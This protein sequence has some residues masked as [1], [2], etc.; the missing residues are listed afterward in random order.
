MKDYYRI[1]EV[2]SEASAEVVTRA[3]RTLAQKYHPDRYHS[4]DKSRMNAH[5]QMLNEAYETLGDETRR[6]RYDRQWQRFEAERPLR[7]RAQKRVMTVQ[8]L[9][10]GFCV[11]VLV[12][13]LVRGG[14]QAFMMSPVVKVVMLGGLLWVLYGLSVRRDARQ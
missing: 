10:Y 5:M 12:A 2:H 13:M 7:E 9:G 14:W 4:S 11:A 6:K 8:K 3:Y 1:L